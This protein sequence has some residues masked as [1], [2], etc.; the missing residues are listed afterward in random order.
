M[1]LITAF[2]VHAYVGFKKKINDIVICLC[3]D[4]IKNQASYHG[5]KYQKPWLSTK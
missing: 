2:Q 1:F 5:C 4:E 3:I